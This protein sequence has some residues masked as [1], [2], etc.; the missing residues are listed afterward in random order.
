MSDARKQANE[1]MAVVKKITPLLKGKDPGVQGAALADLLAIW[2]AG[3]FYPDDPQ[4][5]ALA[6]EQ[7][8]E[9]HLVAVRALIEVNSKTHAEPQ[10]ARLSICAACGAAQKRNLIRCE[11]CGNDLQVH[12]RRPNAS[13]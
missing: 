3:H 7:M 2:L 9:A 13:P 6:R 8:I 5:T 1:A 10:L 11:R 4:A 12:P